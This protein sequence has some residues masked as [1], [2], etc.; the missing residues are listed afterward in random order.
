M[1]SVYLLLDCFRWV[2]MI[3]C[4]RLTLMLKNILNLC[5]KICLLLYFFLLLHCSLFICKCHM[6]RFLCSKLKPN[7]K[8]IKI[9]SQKTFFGLFI[10]IYFILRQWV[11]VVI[12]TLC[13]LCMMA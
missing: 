7:E 8:S 12:T 13:H 3:F 5:Y 9:V 1:I 11:S 4:C 2:K 10:T 6:W